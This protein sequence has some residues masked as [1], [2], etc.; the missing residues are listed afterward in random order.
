M[1]TIT[2][3]RTAAVT[4]TLARVRKIVGESGVKRESLERVRAELI[5]LAQQR[6]LFPDSHFPPPAG[7]EQATLY[8]ITEDADGSY[9]LYVYR[10]KPGKETPPHN[11]TTWAVVAGIEGEEP[12]RQYERVGS[13]ATARLEL[14]REFAVGPGQAA[15]YLPD[16]FHSIH[17]RGE[18]AI[19]HL[20]L[21][22]RR[23]EDLLERESYDAAAGRFVK[24]YVKPEVRNYSIFVPES[25]T[26]RV[27]RTISARM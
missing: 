22:G 7:G 2:V 8:R 23:L 25:F 11:H 13:G 15:A 20:H 6:G 14:R 18:R 19:C 10:P 16:D 9:A 1:D 5:A 3:E 21:Y 4:A 17:I 24:S 12:T 27:Y 26:A